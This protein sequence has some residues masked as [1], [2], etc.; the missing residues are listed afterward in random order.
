M[1]YDDCML[2]FRLIDS[3][4]LVERIASS[5]SMPKNVLCMYSRLCDDMLYEIAAALSGSDFSHACSLVGLVAIITVKKL[6]TSLFTRLF[7]GLSAI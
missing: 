3:L 6:L 2:R 7:D 5:K 4:E 1:H